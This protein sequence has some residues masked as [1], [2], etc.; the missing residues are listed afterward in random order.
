[1]KIPAYN[2]VCV[3][4]LSFMSVFSGWRHA[5]LIRMKKYYCLCIALLAPLM[6]FAVENADYPELQAEKVFLN[7][8]HSKLWPGDTLAVSGGL[9][10]AFLLD[11]T[12]YSRYVYL[13][14]VGANDSVFVRHKIRAENGLF[15]DRIPIDK[16]IVS[17]DYY[18]RGYTRFMANY[19]VTSF[20]MVPVV[21]GNAQTRTDSLPLADSRLSFYPEGGHLVSGKLQN[22]VFR[23]T[24]P[25]GAPLEKKGVL[26]SVSGDTIL[27]G[28]SSDRNGYGCISFVPSEGKEYLLSMK[29]EDKEE[30]FK[31]PLC[32]SN[33]VLQVNLNRHQLRYTV[34]APAKLTESYQLVLMFRGQVCLQKKISGDALSGI[35]DVSE[36]EQ[37]LFAFALIDDAGKV[38][39]ER[40]I[41]NHAGARPAL[42]DHSPLAA[43]QLLVTTDLKYPLIDA[44]SCFENLDTD[45]VSQLDRMLIANTWGRFDWADLLQQRFDYRY[46]PE[47][48]LTFQ[49]KV[50]TELNNKQKEG[51]VIAFNQLN[52]FTY[53]AEI[54]DGAFEV[55]VDDYGVGTTFFIQAYNAKGKSPALKVEADEFEFPVVYPHV[56]VFAG[57]DFT[58]TSYAVE[59]A[60]TYNKKQRIES[61]YDEDQ[62]KVYQIPEI[63]LSARKKIKH[64]ESKPFYGVNLITRETIDNQN[65]TSDMF[66]LL[67]R[68]IGFRIAKI[69]QSEGGIWRYGLLSTRGQSSFLQERRDKDGESLETSADFYDNLRP[70]ELIVLVDGVRTSADYVIRTMDPKQVESIERLTPGQTLKY[71]ANAL[72]GALL[73][74][75]RVYQEAEFKSKGVKLE[76]LGLSRGCSL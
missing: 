25:K 59:S 24:D 56:F 64:I 30:L 2:L 45:A 28:I 72:D 55:A 71:V 65:F 3:L 67:E 44:A 21:V 41:F 43:A 33:P 35:I 32:N 40:V 34:Q 22:M 39:S 29:G 42:P 18:L 60:A 5:T 51:S 73:I 37:G 66:S 54:K 11:S 9:T 75:T 68:M 20:P 16:F 26:V 76:P 23:I 52:G 61:R 63:T 69:E 58:G 8:E 47:Q 17:G 62:N 48:L 13:E 7:V 1:M 49:G 10:D 4:L 57:T 46:M 70:G 15:C 74:K 12:H 38:V 19:K 31:V 6:G 53:D 36:Y 50:F 27:S 14:L